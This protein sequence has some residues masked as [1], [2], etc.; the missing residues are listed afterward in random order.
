MAHRNKSRN[1]GIR[2]VQVIVLTLI[3]LS[4]PAC[5]RVAKEPI[6]KVVGKVL[7]VAKD[8]AM[9]AG[10]DQAENLAQEG[11]QE[12]IETIEGALT[13]DPTL[14]LTN[15]STGYIC[16]VYISPTTDTIWG[17]DQLGNDIIAAGETYSF[18]VAA[19]TYDVLLQDCYSETLFEEY[20]LHITGMYELDFP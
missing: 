3:I 14:R 9:A 7:S 17:R 20:G 5:F 2:A 4:V 10:Q 12:G 1:I 15:N 6:E 16:Y 11:I 19:N 13:A 18:S 8:M